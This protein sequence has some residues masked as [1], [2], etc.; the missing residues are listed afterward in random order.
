MSSFSGGGEDT[1]SPIKARIA[2]SGTPWGLPG[3]A[4]A[5]TVEVTGP[6]NDTVIYIPI[7]VDRDHTYTGIGVYGGFSVDWGA[8]AICRL[9][10]YNA[11]FD[12]DILVP[13]TL[14]EDYGSVSLDTAGLH[15]IGI[16]VALSGGT[17]YF[18]A[19]VH[20]RSGGAEGSLD[21]PNKDEAGSAPITV[22]QT[23]PGA[24]PGFVHRQGTADAAASGLPSP[25]APT[26][27]DS[28]NRARAFLKW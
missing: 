16:S 3:W 15:E 22:G 18:L 28:F 25:A 4:Y 7:Y 14:I 13:D 12:G 2:T 8:G 6:G 19:L 9:G 11:K 23:N 27:V 1:I 10:L 21:A 26:L 24:S 20:N 5:S 17:F